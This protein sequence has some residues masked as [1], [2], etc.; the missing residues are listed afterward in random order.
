MREAGAGLADLGDRA[1]AVERQAHHAAL[2]GERLQDGL[3]DPPHGVRDELEAAR[4]VEA[5]GG[6]D[7]TVVAL[8]DQVGEGEALPLILF[9]DRHHEAQV[10]PH[11]AME[12]LGVALPDALGEVD[13]HGRR[14][15]RNLADLLEV[16]VQHALL[17]G[18]VHAASGKE[19]DACMTGAEMGF[20]SVTP[21][22]RHATQWGRFRRKPPNALIHRHLVGCRLT[23]VG[24]RLR[25]LMG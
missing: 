15:E 11:E 8:V 14:Q 21:A 3:A 16:L 10:G 12:G 17:A 6:L 7:Q 9:G 5:L 1:D 25:A 23:A 20:P 22:L 13:L 4:L 18:D 19:W 24:G 2:L